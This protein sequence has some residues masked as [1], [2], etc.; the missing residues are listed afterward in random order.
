M[1]K[2]DDVILQVSE[3]TMQFFSPWV[4]CL[5]LDLSA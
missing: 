3:V 5:A 4:G 2:R 1:H